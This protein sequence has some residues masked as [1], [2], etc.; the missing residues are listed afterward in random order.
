MNI[1]LNISVLLL[2]FNIINAHDGEDHGD[3]GSIKP[4]APPSPSPPPP[5]PPPITAPKIISS[6]TPS[7]PAPPPPKHAEI[8][9]HTH[10]HAKEQPVPQ[11]AS[12]CTTAMPVA[13]SPVSG[14]SSNEVAPGY[15]KTTST[16]SGVVHFVSMAACFASVL[17]MFGS[18]FLL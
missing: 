4:P 18:I 14:S 3:E 9:G 11:H 2:A 17:S 10:N 7:T 12:G 1:V 6:P 5:P 15:G 13:A 16:N 8:P